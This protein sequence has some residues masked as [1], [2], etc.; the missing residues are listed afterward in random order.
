MTSKDA[1]TKKFELRIKLAQLEQKDGE[2]ISDFI[3]RA[4][5]LAT[6]LP[7]DDVDVGMATLKGMKDEARRDRITFECNKDADYFFSKIKKLVAAAYNEVGKISPFDSGYKKAMQVFL[8]GLPASMDDLLRQ[9]FINT[10][11]AFSALLQGMR[12]LNSAVAGGISVRPSSQPAPDARAKAYR[13]R[14][15]EIKCFK[16]NEMGHYASN[17]STS[18]QPPAITARAFLYYDYSTDQQDQEPPSVAGRM[19]FLKKEYPAMAAARPAPRVRAPPKITIQP[20]GV[21]KLKNKV[22]KRRQGNTSDQI[23]ENNDAEMDEVQKIEDLEIPTHRLEDNANL[24]NVQGPPR[25]KMLKTGKVQ[26]LVRPK[27]VKIPEPIRGMVGHSRFDVNKIF[28]LPIEII[29][30]EF[31]DRSEV[32]VKELAYNFQKAVPRYRIR[33]PKAPAVNLNDAAPSNTILAA[34]NLPPVVTATVF[35]DDGQSMPLMVTFWIERTRLSKTLFDEGSLIKLI[36]KKSVDKLYPR[37]RIYTDG[38]VRVSLANNT[39]TTLD[40]Y[41]KVAVNIEGVECFIKAWIVNVEVYD[42]LLGVG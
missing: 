6:R 35:D 34:Y 21:F 40:K 41:V 32:S 5:E 37:P 27:E 28:K 20:A 7:A 33:K 15:E 8:T 26:E 23:L 36:S 25:T 42:L 11:A 1:A 3:D 39:L 24:Q 30:E 13:P 9:V 14:I 29:V 4:E 16:C 12:L 38:H 31:F 17:C 10:N 22:Q 18:Y 19:M 2:S